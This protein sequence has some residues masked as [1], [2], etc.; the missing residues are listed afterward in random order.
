MLPADT[1]TIEP[2]HV[3]IAIMIHDVFLDVV[4]LGEQQVKLAV[5]HDD[6]HATNEVCL[7]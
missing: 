5:M 7:K 3:H 1:V 2:Y 6:F 4:V